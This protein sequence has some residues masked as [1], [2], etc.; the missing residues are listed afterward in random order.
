MCLNT[1]QKKA[2]IAT[3]DIKVYKVLKVHSSGKP[4]KRQIVNN[5]VYSIVEQVLKSPRGFTYTPGITYKTSMIDTCYGSVD[6]AFHAYNLSPNTVK[7]HYA[8]NGVV[9]ECVVPK[10]SR[11]YKG[12]NNGASKGIASNQIRFVKIV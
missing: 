5:K 1:T 7:R 12:T 6:R 9:V 11:Y 8:R 4:S 2:L 10:G 3:K